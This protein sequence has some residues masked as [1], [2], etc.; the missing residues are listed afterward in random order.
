MPSP[1]ARR[2]G[3]RATASV[4]SSVVLALALLA[5]QPARAEQPAARPQPT[6]EELVL[7][8]RLHDA[9]R[10]GRWREVVESFVALR[11][12]G[13]GDEP[14][15]LLRFA[16]AQAALNET[17]AA[18][19]AAEAVLARSSDDVRGLLLLGRLRQQ[20]GRTD[21]ARELFVRAA[22][23]GGNVLRELAPA[24]VA[25]LLRDSG[26]QGN[27]VLRVMTASQGAEVSRPSRDPFAAPP[28]DDD[29]F[30]GGDEPQPPSAA[31]LALEREV[32]ALLERIARLAE[33]GDDVAGFGAALKELQALL[34]RWEGLG[35]D[36]A[37]D[38][39]EACRARFESLRDVHDGLRLQVALHEANGLLRHMNRL[40]AED[41][42]DD[43]LLVHR[44]VVEVATRLQG[45]SLPQVVRVGEALRLR[46]EPLLRKARALSRIARLNLEVTGVV[47]PP[48][49]DG[50]STAIVDD[51]IRKEGERIELDG[52]EVTVVS[53][54]RS[55][56]RFALD[57]FEFVRPLRLPK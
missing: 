46:A 42:P 35:A 22:R 50:P 2:L 31:R 6:S 32:D 18:T 13:L 49:G 3:A 9:S 48:P 47:L 8:T 24:A 14:G 55:A 19:T 54:R 11:G 10:S 36:V 17:A 41:A 26:A 27:F 34:T 44:Q 16:E 23:A 5:P 12:R 38:R 51:Q 52:V 30:T 56:V 4:R 25:E 21:E 28:L 20:S 45:D 43:A 40:L 1:T 33:R 7:R 53:I 29:V 39:L 37:R 15:L 57:E